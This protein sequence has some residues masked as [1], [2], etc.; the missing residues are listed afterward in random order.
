[1]TRS[2]RWSRAGLS[3][4]LTFAIAA[5]TAPAPRAQTGPGG[6]GLP[7]A[8]AQSDLLRAADAQ[9][10]ALMRGGELELAQVAADSMMP[11][12]THERLIQRYR[13]LPVFGGVIMRQVEADRVCTIFGRIYPGINLATEPAIDAATATARAIA[14]VGRAEA[15]GSDAVLGILPAPLGEPV[16]AWRLLV[17]SSVDVRDVFVNA[18]TGAIERNRTRL[19][20]QLPNIGAGTGVGGDAKKV[21]ATASF[22][23]F[24]A[25]DHSRPG[26]LATYDFAGSLNRLSAFLLNG[27][28]LDADRAFDSDNTWTDGAVVDA[29]VHQG[30]TY[31]YYV[32]RFGR[33]GMDDRN[34][35]V[36]TVVHPVNRED[37][38]NVDANT[39]GLY[40]NN[41]MYLGGGLLMFGDGDGIDFD[42]FAGALDIVAH[43]YSHGVTEYSSNLDYVDESGALNEAFSDI[44][45]T[46]TEFFFQP[47]ESGPRQADWLIGEDITRTPPPFIRSLSDPRSGG[48]PDH[49]SQR[50]FIGTNID[51]GGVHYNATIPTHAFY[52]AVAGGTNRT[53]GISVAGIGQANIERM[54]KIF[55]RAFVFFLGPTSQFSDARAATL[56][57][58]VDL[59][60]ASSNDY[61]QLE[62]AWTAVGVN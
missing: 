50:R 61:T 30:W 59:Y 34:L 57:A 40:V 51:N 15:I 60:G 1:M 20:D 14:A 45:G 38:D 33:H 44:M 29:H 16:L 22:Q 26:T 48:Q 52:L 4:A 25:T 62:R 13:G 12:R 43:E 17:R 47:A 11:G 3:L 19:R 58:A 7:F 35:E 31:D 42:Y 53:S 32:K 18:V 36:D 41:A 10:E 21:S 6:S 55:Y 46:A 23:G 8:A 49:Y 5:V 24:V 27:F 54:E 9:V 37:A 28:L 56:Q 39:R 2:R